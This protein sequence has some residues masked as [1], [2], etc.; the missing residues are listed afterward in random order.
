M[1]K[2]TIKQIIIGLSIFILFYFSSYIQLI[3]IYLFKLDIKN[4][5]GNIKVGLNMFSNIILLITLIL[6]YR[7]EL[8]KEWKK[9]KDKIYS[10]IDF[11]FKYWFIGLIVMFISNIFINIIL[12]N[13]QA[14]NEQA[15]QE[16]ISY[17]PILMVPNA[18]IIAPIIEEITF[19]K[20]FKNMIKNKWAFILTSGII[21]GA[22]HVVTNVSSIIDLLYII[23][24]SSLGIAFAY[25]YYKTDTIYTSIAMHMI[26]NTV[27]TII[28]IM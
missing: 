26:H 19:R 25:M 15:V 9:F 1:K 5:S 4:L 20:A 16:M 7:K 28:S 24:Y 14:A 27:L 11:G 21:F 2:E 23:P 6:I 8:Y 10:N 12:K 22:L 3:P 18:G 13:G 17:A